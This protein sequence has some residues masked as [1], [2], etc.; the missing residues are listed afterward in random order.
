MAVIMI[1]HSKGK[2]TK[3][4]LWMLILSMFAMAILAQAAGIDYLKAGYEAD[5]RGDKDEAIHLYTK[6]IISSELSAEKQAIAYY[7][8]GN[9]WGRV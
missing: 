4:F 1:L 5:N 8:R 6:A 3:Q 2:C 9:I 7:N